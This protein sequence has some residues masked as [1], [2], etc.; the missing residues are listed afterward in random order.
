MN[1][2]KETGHVFERFK[3]AL[4]VLLEKV[5]GDPSLKNR[6]PLFMLEDLMKAMD[7]MDE[8]RVQKVLVELGLPAD[9]QYGFTKN[10]SIRTPIFITT[11]MVEQSRLTKKEL[12]VLFSDYKRAFDAVDR[13]TGKLLAKMRLGISQSTCMRERARDEAIE[14]ELEIAAG[15]CSKFTG[16]RMSRKAGW[17]Q[18]GARA[19]AEWKRNIDVNICAHMEPHDGTPA[20]YTD[21]W[22]TYVEYHGHWY[23][24]DPTIFCG[25]T[26]NV[27]ARISTDELWSQFSGVPIGAEKGHYLAIKFDEK[28]KMI[29]HDEHKIHITNCQSGVRNEVPH[30]GNDEP[31]R[32]LGFHLAGSLATDQSFITASSACQTELDVLLRKAL[33]ADEFAGLIN[34]CVIPRIKLGFCYSTTSDAALRKLQSKYKAHLKR[35]AHLPSSFPNNILFGAP[36]RGGIGITSFADEVNVSRVLAFFQHTRGNDTERELAC[37]AIKSSEML[38]QEDIPVMERIGPRWIAHEWDHTWAG[39][40]AEFCVEKGF[41]ITG[42]QHNRG[43]RADDITIMSLFNDVNKLTHRRLLAGCR[44]F[45]LHWVSQLLSEDSSTFKTA[46]QNDKQMFSGKYE[47]Y[48]Y[49]EDCFGN[50]VERVSSGQSKQWINDVKNAVCHYG[51]ICVFGDYHQNKLRAI[52]A[53]D[54]VLIAGDPLMTPKIVIATSESDNRIKVLNTSTQLRPTSHK[55]VDA[56]SRR[57]EN[58]GLRSTVSGAVYS[59]DADSEV[60]IHELSKAIIVETQFLPRKNRATQFFALRTEDFLDKNAFIKGGVFF[61]TAIDTEWFGKQRGRQRESR[62]HQYYLTEQVEKYGQIMTESN[63]MSNLPCVHEIAESLKYQCTQFKHGAVLTGGDASG[64]RAHTESKCAHCFVVF[65]VGESSPVWWDKRPASDVKVL[66]CGGSIDWVEP[67]QQNSGRSEVICILTIL[68]KF[69]GLGIDILHST[70]YLY[71]R[72]TVRVVQGWSA[73]E[74]CN[75]TNRDLWESIAFLLDEYQSAGTSFKV[76][77]NKAHPENWKNEISEYSALEMVAHLTDSIVAIVKDE[78]VVRPDAPT[79]PGRSRWRLMHGGSEVIGPLSKSMQHINRLSYIAQHFATSRSGTIGQLDHLTFWPAIESELK[80]NRTMTSRV[81]VAKFLYQWWA[82]NAKLAQRKQLD[83]DE[84]D[85]ECCEC[86]QVETAHHILCE[87]T[88]ER[89]VNVRRAFAGQRAKIIE[90][91]P[92]PCSVKTTFREIHELKS[93][94]TYPDLSSESVLWQDGHVPDSEAKLISDYQSGGKCPLPWFNK[95]PLPACLVNSASA[96]LSVEYD[97]AFRFCKKW[98]KSALDEGLMIWRAR[99]L[100]KHN[101]K[102]GEC[103]SYVDLRRDYFDAVRYLDSIGVELPAR[104]VI[105]NMRREGMQKYIDKADD[106]RASNSMLSFVTVDGSQLTRDEMR[107]RQRDHRQRQRV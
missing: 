82:T 95:G 87:C 9:G 7:K 25:D 100:N 66:A 2:S 96:I 73:T 13:C 63:I 57:W 72:N 24:D 98:F 53:R 76:F 103:I 62:L 51:E 26:V 36:E 75:C 23:A 19:G 52:A 85:A 99:N 42:G 77:H 18:G 5:P 28:G 16:S 89:Y 78:V 50:R 59:V 107:A 60:E 67:M 33:T 45:N 30:L 83:V 29:D 46:Y 61:R 90:N 21:E 43:H 48:H 86:G 44:H 55:H 79:L 27:D 65:G 74:W 34:L 4:L 14:G 56:K 64:T 11:Q 94:G 70:D 101:G 3:I 37:A 31:V 32:T 102:L 104:N 92:Y 17:S 22:G 15:P 20:T 41:Q 10:E 6:R 71:A 47:F 35:I 106:T 84:A 49:V 39:R 12:R 40:I 80:S 97:D 68:L 38:T 93:D 105:R 58:A 91:S 69:R 81:A 54:I 1:M 88:C 8:A